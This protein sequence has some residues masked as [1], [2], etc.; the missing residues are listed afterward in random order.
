MVK[1]SNQDVRKANLQ[2]YRLLTAEFVISFLAGFG[3]A[4]S[5]LVKENHYVK[6]G[7]KD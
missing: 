4:L 3:L 7:D 2:Y 5:I 1:N 6:R